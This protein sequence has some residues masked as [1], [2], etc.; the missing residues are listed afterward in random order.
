MKHLLFV[1]AL[2]GGF[3]FAAHHNSNAESVRQ[4]ANVEVT[5]AYS[6]A[7]TSAQKNG[8][9]FF[10][11]K[12]L[13]DQDLKITSANASN[14]SEAAE[15]H[16]HIMDGDKM[17]MREVDSYDVAAHETLE[18]APHGNHIML[19]GLK[20]PLSPEL[21]AE[22]EELKGK[23]PLLLRFE[24]GSITTVQVEIIPPG[25]KPEGKENHSHHE[26]HGK[27]HDQD[28]SHH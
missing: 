12:N 22:V 7:T 18:L 23:F 26:D 1:L 15:L 3:Y 2:I 19:M 10:T 21:N 27:S 11:L 14:V 13:G 20:A 24:D 16:T 17:M 4:L 5:N 25:T 28:H 6:Y 9:V 8:A